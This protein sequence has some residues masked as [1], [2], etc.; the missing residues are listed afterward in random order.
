[1]SKLAASAGTTIRFLPKL[2]YFLAS[3]LEVPFG[4]NPPIE[5]A[6]LTSSAFRAL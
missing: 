3:P 2:S 5:H 4:L 6:R 1:L